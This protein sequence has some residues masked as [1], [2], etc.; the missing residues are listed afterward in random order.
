MTDLIKLK[1]T[2]KHVAHDFIVAELRVNRFNYI[3]KLE[4]WVIMYQ[5][6]AEEVQ[7]WRDDQ[8]ARL[9]LGLDSLNN[10]PPALPPY[11]TAQPTDDELLEWIQRCR[12]DPANTRPV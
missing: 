3:T 6:Y 10:P 1:M 11:P 5:Q 12:K 7:N 8:K 4:S 9:A 2:T